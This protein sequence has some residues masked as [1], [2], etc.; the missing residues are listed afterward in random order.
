MVNEQLQPPDTAAAAAAAAAEEDDADAEE[1]AAT[2]KRQ[3]PSALTLTAE[4]RKATAPW[5]SYSKSDASTFT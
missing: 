2:A 4:V 5:S 3:T 1:A